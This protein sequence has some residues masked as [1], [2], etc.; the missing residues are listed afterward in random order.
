MFLD[1]FNAF[2][3]IC[4]Q[5]H[6]N[7]DGDSLAAGYGLYTYFKEMGKAVRMVYSG[8]SQISK[9]ALKLMVER[10]DIPIEYISDAPDCDVLITADCQYAGGNITVFPVPR[11]AMVD[12]HPVCVPID[13]WC[14]IMEEYGSCCTV[15][16]ELM[17]EVGFDINGDWKLATALFYGLYTDTGHLSEIY[18]KADREMRDFLKIDRPV[19]D[20]MINS[21]ITQKELRIA[22][23]ALSDYYYNKDYHFAIFH[24]KPCD[25]NLLGLISDLGIQVHHIDLCVVYC[26]TPIGY[27]F[28]VRSNMNEAY[29]SQ[30]AVFLSK[31][32][33]SGGGHLNKAGGVLLKHRLGPIQTETEIEMIIREKVLDFERK[34]REEGKD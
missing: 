20:C 1:K 16:W 12:H 5:C 33:G 22:G 15:V 10:L 18:H 28:S 11:A 13:E 32:L 4:I 21:N 27:K 26:E 2:E 7:P 17:R 29:A 30:L 8:A 34:V 6:D 24:T 19:L 3:K 14:C 31:G 9:P 23:E 25:P